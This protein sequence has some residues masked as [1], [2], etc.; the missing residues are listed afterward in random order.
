[1]TKK[2]LLPLLA[3]ACASSF[4]GEILV[5]MPRSLALTFR[6]AHSDH[7][8][9]PEHWVG[10]VESAGLA[11]HPRRNKIIRLD[12]RQ[13]ALGA[14][15]RETFALRR[16]DPD[17]AYVGYHDYTAL[18]AELRRLEA[19]YP[20]LVKMK[21]A[22]KSV[23]GRELWYVVVTDNVGQ[24]ENEPKLIYHAN[25]H[26][27]EVVGRELTIYFL[28]YVLENY[29]KDLRVTQLL[30]HSEL[31]IMPSMN[32]DGFELGRRANA[33]GKDLN[34]NFP[35]RFTSTSD[36]P[37]GREIE[38]QHMM[39]LAAEN[40]FIYGIN[41][42]GGEICFNLPW[43]NIKN[44]DVNKHG[45]DVFFHPIGREYTE[46]NSPM[47]QNHQA[48]FN[49]GLT[50]GYEWYPVNGGIN[51]WFNFFR[52][53]LHSVIEV[54]V[55]KWPSASQL[56]KFWEDNREAMLTYLMH[57]LRGVHLEVRDAQG[58]LVSR[59]TIKIAAYPKRPVTFDTGYVHRIAGAGTHS[60]EI[61]AAGFAAKSLSVDAQNFEGAFVPVVLDSSLD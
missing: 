58:N 20:A 5:K 50:Y 48:N 47:Y 21:T 12:E 30:N 42:H 2:L 27:D 52:R 31:F 36:T 14:Y 4:A 28:Q 32:P 45:D 33:N 40:H 53:S 24:N 8:F 57:G 10:Y 16:V 51:D 3:L 54:S 39:K 34:R 18:T 15:D 41:W 43:G 35:D 38:V 22:G 44:T 46:A 26:G 9:H 1:M 55:T 19:A 61:S 17:L 29:G 56:P 6:E 13:W 7:Y 23:Q 11:G 49:H 59:P 25:M 37:A 60:V